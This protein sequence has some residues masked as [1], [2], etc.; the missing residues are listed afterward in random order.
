MPNVSAV[1]VQVLIPETRSWKQ[2]V[3]ATLNKAR[4]TDEANFKQL[5]SYWYVTGKV[6]DRGQ[7][8]G[9]V[10]VAHRGTRFDFEIAQFS[11]EQGAFQGRPRLD[12]IGL[13]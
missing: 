8:M 1:N 2:R 3:M 10:A 9:L 12:A 5:L 13:A 11:N 4:K 7:A 6:T